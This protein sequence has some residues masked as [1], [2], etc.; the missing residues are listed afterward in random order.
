MSN[1]SGMGLG[2]DIFLGEGQSKTDL[3]EITHLSCI[4]T[5]LTVLD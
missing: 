3:S 1:I 4:L 2:I 5:E